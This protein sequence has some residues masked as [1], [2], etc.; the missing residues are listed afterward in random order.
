M[1]RLVLCALLLAPGCT[2]T[3]TIQPPKASALRY[4]A[5]A[6]AARPELADARSAKVFSEGRLKVRVEFKDAGNEIAYLQKHVVEALEARGVQLNGAAPS[7]DALHV[8]V[9]ELGVRN[10]RVS[11][12]SPMVTFTRF[13][14]D[15]QR[16]TQTVRIT[17]YS[18]QTKV[19]VWSMNELSEPCYNRPLHIVVG[20]V[21]AKL[22]RYFIGARSSAAQVQSLVARS[23]G[24]R[25]LALVQTLQEL[26]WSNHPDALPV[27]VKFASNESE[28][29]RGAALGA[30][31]SLGMAESLSMLQGFLVPGK[32]H[33]DRYMALKA[34]GDLD[35]PEALEVLREL[36]RAGADMA[37][38]EI[39]RLYLEARPVSAAPPS[40]ASAAT[41][42]AP[43]P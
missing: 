23:A 39:I 6:S 16:G 40:V 20:E 31:G 43:P 7:A 27:L 2:L 22:N 1:T 11:S 34:I 37:M 42:L 24:E 30:I 4:E 12:F 28:E 15:V 38:K 18:K 10:H 29:V 8:K 36:D 13:S 5:P 17:A 21:A 19:P 9:R 35:T 41:M 26:G 32:S 14:A 33:T 25:G 3:Y